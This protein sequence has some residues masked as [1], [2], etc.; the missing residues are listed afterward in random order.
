MQEGRS[1]KFNRL[2]SLRGSRTLGLSGL[3]FKGTDGVW[4]LIRF[5]GSQRHSRNDAGSHDSRAPLVSQRTCMTIASWLRRGT[6]STSDRHLLASAV[7]ALKLWITSVCVPG[8]SITAISS[9]GLS[10]G[11]PRHSLFPCYLD[12]QPPKP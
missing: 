12:M 1:H 6:V 11:N 5:W 9:T 3:G 8:S 10:F 2:P 7:Y 4:C